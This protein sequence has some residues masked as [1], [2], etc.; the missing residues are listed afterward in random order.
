MDNL[1]LGETVRFVRRRRESVRALVRGVER[2]VGLACLVKNLIA[3]FSAGV[4]GLCRG[5]LFLEAAAL[6]LEGGGSMRHRT[7]HSSTA[8]PLDLH[9]RGR[10]A[11]AT[12]CTSVLAG[13]S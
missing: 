10:V 5:G 11:R 6:P 9:L 3:E 12:T 13:G 8:T 4:L 2:F 1:R 7:T